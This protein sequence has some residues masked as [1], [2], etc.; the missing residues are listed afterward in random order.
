MKVAALHPKINLLPQKGPFQER[1]LSKHH[2]AQTRNYGTV[3][4]RN[5]KQ[6]PRMYKTLKI[7]GYTL[8]VSPTHD[9]SEIIIC[10]RL[11]RVIIEQ[12]AQSWMFKLDIFEDL[13]QAMNLHKTLTWMG[14]FGLNIMKPTH[15]VSN[16]T[17]CQDL[18]RTMNKKEKAK[19]HKRIAGLKKKPTTVLCKDHQER[20]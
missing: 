5:P 1:R 7:M 11:V 12:P 14:C 15:L 8:G 18:A 3:D 13:I 10:S 17:T 16:M 4:G 9:A 20:W 19:F 6:P 2:F